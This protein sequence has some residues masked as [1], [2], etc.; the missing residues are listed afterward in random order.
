MAAALHLDVLMFVQHF[1]A[2]MHMLA[3]ER[4]LSRYVFLAHKPQ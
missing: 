3:S 2:M 4:R 1:F